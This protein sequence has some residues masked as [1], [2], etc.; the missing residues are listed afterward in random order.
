VNELATLVARARDGDRGAFDA[1]CAA[2]RERLLRFLAGMGCDEATAE[3]L[4]QDCLH[5]AWE[6][7]AQLEDA[8]R[9]RSWLLA[10]VVHAGRSHARSGVQRERAGRLDAVP[11]PI[12]HRRGLLTSLVR[13]EAATELALA[14]DRL[15]VL[16]REAFVLH[17]LEGCSFPQMAEICDAAVGTLQVRA[18]RA[19][20]LLRTQ[21][22]DLVD[23]SWLA[24]RS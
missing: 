6:R 1:L 21:L 8:S 7:I 12:D 19:R 4:V 24:E 22:G 9:F 18:H 13:R 23:E 16:L 2:E 5:R 3:D 15:P 17:H 11:T 14:I 10:I 20:A